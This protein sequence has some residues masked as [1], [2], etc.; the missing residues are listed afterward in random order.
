MQRHIN[1]V[2]IRNWFKKK[3]QKPAP[4]PQQERAFDRFLELEESTQQALV[5]EEKLSRQEQDAI[6]KRV[7]PVQSAK[8]YDAQ[9]GQFAMDS[10]LGFSQMRGLITEAG[11]NDDRI[12]RFYGKHSFIGW[13]LCAMISQNWLVANACSIPADDAVRPGWKNIIKSVSGEDLDP[14][15]L[16]ELTLK[17][18]RLAEKC[19]QHAKNSRVF[20]V[21]YALLCIDGIDYSQPFNLDGVRPGSFKGIS[22]ID[23][24]WITPQWSAGALNNPAS[25]DFYEPTYYQTNGAGR[26]HASHII[27]LVHEEVPDLLKPSYYFGGLSLTQEIYERVYAAERTANEAPLLALTKRLLVVPTNLKALAAKPKIAWD[28]MKMLVFGRDNQG[29]YFTEEGEKNQVHQV[30]TSLSDFDA[31][32]MSQYQLVA[33]IAHIPAHKLL[34]TDPKGLNNNG[35]YT[36]KDYNQELQ[37]LQEKALRPLIER[38]NGVVLRSD[39]SQLKG[40]KE[41]ITEFN[42]IDMPTELEKAQVE[43]QQAQAASAYVA[44]GILSPEEVRK[45]LRAEKGGKYADIEEELPA[46]E[47]PEDLQ[48]PEDE[49]GQ[50]LPSGGLDSADWDENKHP[51]KDNGQFGTGSGG[52]NASVPKKDAQNLNAQEAEELYKS[53]WIKAVRTA[54]AQLPKSS[55]GRPYLQNGETVVDVPERLAGEVKK[56]ILNNNK[57]REE[58]IGAVWAI[59]HL[60]ELFSAAV[61]ETPEPDVHQRKNVKSVIRYNIPFPLIIEGKN[62]AFN[63]KFTVREFEDGRKVLA[64]ELLEINKGR[65]LGL[66]ALKTK[67]E[68]PET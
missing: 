61:A 21:S 34:K 67:K 18:Y 63:T 28:L 57:T 42:P 14:A 30:D 37:S 47:M 35:E 27:K 33:A 16:T 62:Y 20:G 13:Q 4:A 56:E 24:V 25:P 59:R 32:I 55:N 40:V 64:P 48:L 38:V 46:E 65:D 50:E 22:I 31:V 19:R 15:E 17:K 6:L 7:F 23:P 53:D 8:L 29:V 36:I 49:S 26:I 41:V 51:R 10:D 52:K 12:F 44:A 45:A 11:R 5:K 1:M 68:D 60:P 9:T 66:Y 54:I 2:N 3:E 39:L 43:S 58:K